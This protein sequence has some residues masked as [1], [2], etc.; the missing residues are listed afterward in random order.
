MAQQLNQV[1]ERTQVIQQTQDEQYNRLLEIETTAQRTF[2]ESQRFFQYYG[3]YPELEELLYNGRSI[4]Q[5]PKA[6]YQNAHK[7]V[8]NMSRIKR[9]KPLVKV[10]RS[11]DPHP[12]RPTRGLAA[13]RTDRVGRPLVWPPDLPSQLCATSLI[14]IMKKT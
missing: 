12:G 10:A 14:H 9:W 2:D 7:T 8:E 3:Y 4:S 13:R 5:P 6:R 11:A 1:D